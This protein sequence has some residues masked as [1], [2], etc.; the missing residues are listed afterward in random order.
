MCKLDID[1]VALS[2]L[3]ACLQKSDN[4][5][6]LFSIRCIAANIGLLQQRLRTAAKIHELLH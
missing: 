5:S 4:K 1:M 6:A 2:Y 3:Q